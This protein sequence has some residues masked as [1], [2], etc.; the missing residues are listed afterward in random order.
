[1]TDVFRVQL[2]RYDAR[3]GRHVEHDPRSRAYPAQAAPLS[4]ADVVHEHYG[5]VLNQ[6]Q[7]GSCTGNAGAQ[8]LMTAPLRRRPRTMTQRKAV[9]LYSRATVIDGFDGDYPP[10]DT[11][12]S[13][14][15][16]CKAMVETGYISSYEWA[17]GID[18][19]KAA[20]GAGPVMCGTAWYES[21]FEPDRRG[22]VTIGGQIAGGHEYLCLGYVEDGDYFLFLN[23]W[24]RHWGVP[25]P[26]DSG[27]C[28]WMSRDTF[29]SLLED[30]GDV[31]QPIA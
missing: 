11:G 28:F 21:M 20:L 6:G 10:D 14:L 4:A 22:E 24:G 7:L 30:Q 16:V 31:V 12:S 25:G 26:S 9:S 13:G 3:L 29:G 5:V 19:A 8:S 2:P 17:F 1:M 27:G 18:H 15:A 23:S